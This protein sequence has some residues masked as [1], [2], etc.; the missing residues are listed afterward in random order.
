M[1][2][3]NEERVVNAEATQD[4]TSNN[5]SVARVQGVRNLQARQSSVNVDVQCPSFTYIARENDHD[6]FVLDENYEQPC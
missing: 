1:R 3:E 5:I 4:V 2:T 6:V